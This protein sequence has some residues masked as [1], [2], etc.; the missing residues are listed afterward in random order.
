MLT[1]F[2]RQLECEQLEDRLALDATGFVQGLYQSVL[3]RAADTAGLN[4]WVA[5]IQNGLSHVQVA[6]DFWR[7]AEHRIDE[8]TS[9]YLNI[10]NR[11]PDAAGLNLWVTEMMNGTLNEQG[12][13]TAFYVSGEFQVTHNNAQTFVQGLFLDILGRLPSSSEQ[14]NWVRLVQ[15]DGITPVT[16]SILTSTE[17]YTDII[18]AYYSRYLNRTPDPSG[19]GHWLSALET[20]QAS[21]ESVAEQILGSQEY[22]NL[23]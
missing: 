1:N 13:E 9:Y 11:S 16:A 12:V 17:S 4:N 20:G 23:H 14:A 10:L 6:T 22:A 8:V 7:S 19:L 18:D 21:V 5:Q 15:A 2:V 3:G